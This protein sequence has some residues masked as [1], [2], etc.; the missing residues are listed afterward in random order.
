L[1]SLALFRLIALLA[2]W[3]SLPAA[4][5]SGHPGPAWAPE[6]LVVAALAASGSLYALGSARLWRRAGRGRGIRA[7]EAARWWT[8]WAIL[9]MALASPLDDYGA[10]L[11]SAHMIQ[12]ELL[13]VCAAPL[14]VAGRPLE[15]WAWALAPAWRRAIA[16]IRLPG[17]SRAWRGITSVNG[18]WCAHALALWAWHV[19]LLFTA[20]LADEGI[21]ALQHA[22]FL[23]TALAFWW[24]ALPRARER[25]AGGALA[26]VFTTML[27]TGALGALLTFAPSAWYATDA[28]ARAFGL[29]A[30]EDQQLGGLVMWLPGSLAYLVAGLV[31]VGS[32]LRSSPADAATWAAGTRDRARRAPRHPA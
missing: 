29:T 20:A 2:A 3:A 17:V 11:F 21:H 6:P 26:S 15:A 31:L 28:G 25:P 14:V 18:A 19:P 24:S 10:R 12:H 32:W 1:G 23:G 13:M 22:C 30:L 5:H 9:C 27:H 8:G 4:A 16:A 7:A